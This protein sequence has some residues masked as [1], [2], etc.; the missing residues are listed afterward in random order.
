MFC[1]KCKSFICAPGNKCSVCGHVIKFKSKSKRKS[2]KQK[3][4]SKSKNSSKKNKS[5]KNANKK[6]KT[7]SNSNKKSGK[8]KKGKKNKS[9]KKTTP[10]LRNR[11]LG[12]FLGGKTRVYN[13]IRRA[14]FQVLGY[15]NYR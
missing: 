14:E 15:Y 7:K 13:D 12:G 3:N 2:K 1:P 10:T 11:I 6:S 5:K 9:K 4:K 8:K